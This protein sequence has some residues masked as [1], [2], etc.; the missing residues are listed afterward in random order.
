LCD[1]LAPSP[2]WYV[3]GS[4]GAF[5]AQP[6]PGMTEF[7]F[8]LDIA[9]DGAGDVHVVFQRDAPDYSTSTIGYTA[10]TADGW[11]APVALIDGARYAAIA[12]GSGGEVHIVASGNGAMAYAVARDGVFNIDLQSVVT[13]AENRLLAIDVDDEGRPHIAYLTNETDEGLFDLFYA[14]G[15]GY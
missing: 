5:V 8:A 10:L 9:V 4:S 12:V 1:E 7:D 11:L 2:V 13:A 15:I 14:A 3:G 6:I